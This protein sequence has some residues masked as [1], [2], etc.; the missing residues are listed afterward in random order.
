MQISFSERWNTMYFLLWD[1]LV[2]Q[3]RLAVTRNA[4]VIESTQL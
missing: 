4:Q 2:L 1:L 3:D